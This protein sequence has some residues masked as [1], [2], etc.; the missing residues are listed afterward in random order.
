MESLHNPDFRFREQD[1]NR[2][3]IQLNQGDSVLLTGIRRT[4]KSELIR[5]ALYGYCQQGNAVDYLDVQHENDLSVFYRKLL[6]SLLDNTPQD[7]HDRLQSILDNSLRLPDKLTQWLQT[8][9]KKIEVTKVV[10]IEFQTPEQLRTYWPTLVE[11]IV[12]LLASQPRQQLPV[13]AIDELPFM[14]ENLLKRE[15]PSQELREMLAS[16]RLLRGAGLRMVIGGSVS[17]ENLLSLN[18]ITHTVLGGLFRLPVKPFTREEAEQFLSEKFAASYPAQPEPMNLILDTLPDYV[19][20]IL[21]IA[22]G[23][24]QS[25]KDL[26]A[27]QT[28]L[29]N[30]VLPSIRKSFVQQFQER[31][32]DNYSDEQR[33]CA[34][35]ILDALA[36]GPIAG[37]MLDSRNFPKNY[38]RVLTQLQ[39]DNYIE[40]APNGGWRFSLNIIRLW[41]RNN[42]GMN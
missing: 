24:L 37:T 30:E 4:G 32:S 31:L 42:R 18:D 29:D 38:L 27:C 36:Q 34:E 12:E 10:N 3:Q 6:Q 35:Q 14:L 33:D 11:Q 5:A 1:I 8:R 28:C 22:H 26:P 25:C 40:D 41:W 39:Y 16:L 15:I 2:L 21:K 13:I 17:F 23:F 9:I 7:F 20:E 19:P